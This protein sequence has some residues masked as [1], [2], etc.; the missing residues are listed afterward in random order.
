[1]SGTVEQ[2]KAWLVFCCSL[3]GPAPLAS[4]S[5]S[6]L[7]LFPHPFSNCLL[8]TRFPQCNRP[9]LLPCPSVCVCDYT[10]THVQRALEPVVGDILLSFIFIAA[11]FPGVNVGNS[12][13][14]VCRVCGV[15]VPAVTGAVVT[16]QEGFRV[17]LW[18]TQYKYELFPV[19]CL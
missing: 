7:L 10:C 11:L 9:C 15:T 19:V 18:Q 8:L 3:Y 14:E 13:I 12:L 5:P 16:P 1:M 6:L 17:M 4:L 2:D